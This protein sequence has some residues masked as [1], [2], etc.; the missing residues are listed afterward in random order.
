MDYL[1]R[2]PDKDAS[3]N[4]SIFDERVEAFADYYSSKLY[5]SIPSLTFAYK[6]KESME[7]IRS[8]ML[9]FLEQCV[10]NIAPITKET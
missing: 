9:L 2:I 8:F 10:T 1:D 5:N 6:E 4:D 3:I 7:I